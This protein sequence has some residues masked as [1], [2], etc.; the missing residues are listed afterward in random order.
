MN[1][2]FIGD[3]HFKVKNVEYIPL[4]ISKIITIVKDHDPSF[5]V[6]AG[7]LLDN[8]DVVNVEP[9]NLALDFI[10]SL[11]KLKRVF[12]L[13]GNHDYQN[14]QQF[15]TDK[16]WMNALKKWPNVTIVDNITRYAN[17]LMVPYVPPGKFLDALHD[18]NLETVD[19]IFAHQ[20]FYGC[21]M[22]AIT[23]QIGDKWE[24]QWP[25]VISGHIH[26]KQWSQS[27]IYYPGSA[28]QHAFGQSTNNT[29]T[30]LYFDPTFVFQEIDLGMPRLYIK[31][32]SVKEAVKIAIQNTFLKKYK[33][34]ISGTLEEFKTFKKTQKYND[35]LKDD[36]VIAF[37][38]HIKIDKVVLNNHKTF[39]DILTQ[40]VKHDKEL[41]NIYNEFLCL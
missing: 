6:V 7:D 21:K 39:L 9:L 26:N 25:L 32:I 30:M 17:F 33:L 4:F 34:V 15:L 20:E 13:V 23:S 37:K 38:T 18:E 36:I 10:D 11:S 40:K 16:H 27:N 19:A 2:L 5:V 41:M 3:P 29:I 24:I 8:H 1:V 14:N 28:M 35:L 31:Y 22:G 12:V